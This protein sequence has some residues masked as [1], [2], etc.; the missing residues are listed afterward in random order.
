MSLTATLKSLP[1]LE[2][3]S[4]NFSSATSPELLM[5]TFEQHCEFKRT[6][7]GTILQPVQIG[8]WLVIFCDE[9]NLPA[10]DAY[11]TPRVITFL[12]QLIEQNGFWRTSDHTWITLHRIQIIGT[13]FFPCET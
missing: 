10:A 4:L 6:Q 5:K 8:K 13:F 3:V 11:G 2:L 1:D 12:R 9:I 7:D